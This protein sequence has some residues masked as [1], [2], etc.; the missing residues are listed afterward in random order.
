[1]CQMNQKPKG[2]EGQN[3]LK[4]LFN[5]NVMASKGIF[6]VCDAV[7]ALRSDGVN[8][9]LTVLGEN[10]PDDE[11]GLSALGRRVDYY[12]KCDG[13]YFTGSVSPALADC[14]VDRADVVVL[15]STYKSECQ[16]LA[17]ISAMSKGKIVL[18]ADTAALR[19]TARGYN[20]AAFVQRSVKKITA[21]LSAIHSKKP[22]NLRERDRDREMVRQRFSVALFDAKIRSLIYDD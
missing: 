12:A 7:I 13:I 4:V 1:M 2:N 16:P 11:L 10:V 5:S 8:V 14:Y 22:L 18:L 6:D 3:E 17:I 21:A 15:V 20:H 9:A 19:E